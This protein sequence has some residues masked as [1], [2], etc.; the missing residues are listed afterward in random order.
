MGKLKKYTLERVCIFYPSHRLGISSPREVRC[1]SPTAA[2]PLLY[3]I[4]RQ[5]AS[6]LQL[7]DIQHF[8]LMIC[9]SFVIGD[10]HASGVIFGLDFSFVP[11]SQHHLTEGQ[12]HFEQREN[13]ISHLFGTNER[14]CASRRQIDKPS[15]M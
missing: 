3:L 6:Y 5:R 15:F 1:I 7:D 12:Y 13:I 11:Q 2:E 10:I 9:N 8:V 14:C 4:T